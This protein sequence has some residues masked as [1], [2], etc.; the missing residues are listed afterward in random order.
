MGAG[1]WVGLVSSGVMA[2]GYSAWHGE[3]SDA[4]GLCGRRSSGGAKRLTRGRQC[5]GCATVVFIVGRINRQVLR[6][7]D[8]KP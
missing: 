8:S 4:S 3:R 1:G 7:W 2:C 6:R 5:K